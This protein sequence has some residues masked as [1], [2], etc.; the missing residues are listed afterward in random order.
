MPFGAVGVGCVTVIV[1]VAVY[2][3]VVGAEDHTPTAV[4]TAAP[5]SQKPAA[6]RIAATKSHTRRQDEQPVRFF[7]GHQPGVDHRGDQGVIPPHH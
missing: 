6:L 4:I 2:A 3:P 5:R 7:G 1:I